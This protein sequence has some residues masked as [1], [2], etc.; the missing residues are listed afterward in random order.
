MTFSDILCTS[1]Q[2][3]VEHMTHRYF[4]PVLVL[5]QM[6]FHNIRHRMDVFYDGIRS[7]EYEIIIPGTAD[8]AIS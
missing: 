5:Q 3:L 2:V 8:T 6:L 1:I 4:Y 7:T